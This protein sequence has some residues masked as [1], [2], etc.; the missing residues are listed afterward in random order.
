MM[1]HLDLA[2]TIDTNCDQYPGSYLYALSDR[3]P[4][5]LQ[6]LRPREIASSVRER[7]HDVT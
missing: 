5:N 7:L 2:S 4:G 6:R 1:F 3:G